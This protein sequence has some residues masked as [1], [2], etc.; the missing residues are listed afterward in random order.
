M[1]AIAE[2]NVVCNIYLKNK[3]NWFWKTKYDIFKETVTKL[4]VYQSKLIVGWVCK[5]SVIK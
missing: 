2:R 1:H 5:I 4:M 3:K